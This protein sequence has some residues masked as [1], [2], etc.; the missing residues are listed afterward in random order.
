M[1]TTDENDFPLE[2]TMDILFS[3]GRFR[4]ISDTNISL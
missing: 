3:K 1:A 2:D 4:V